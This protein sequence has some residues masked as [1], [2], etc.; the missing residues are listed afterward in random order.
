MTR[1]LAP[2]PEVICAARESPA[3]LTVP[4]SRRR[5]CRPP[6]SRTPHATRCEQKRARPPPVTLGAAGIPLSGVVQSS[7]NLS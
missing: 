3:A 1:A 5:V 6:A 2:T 4:H 7:G